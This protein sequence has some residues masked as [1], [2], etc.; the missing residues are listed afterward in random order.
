M[1]KK[2]IALLMTVV[3][4]PGLMGCTTTPQTTDALTSTETSVDEVQSAPL[5]EQLIPMGDIT[6]TKDGHRYQ[7][8]AYQDRQVKNVIYVSSNVMEA[9]FD[10]NARESVALDGKTFESL[11]AMCEEKQVAS[12]TYDDVLNAVYI[13]SYL[14]DSTKATAALLS[15]DERIA[16]YGLGE[17]SEEAITYQEFF[18]LVDKA[19][20]IANAQQLSTWKESFT[21]MRNSQA[22]LTRFEGMVAILRMVLVLGDEYAE[23]NDVDYTILETIGESGWQELDQITQG[24]QNLGNSL[25]EPNYPYTLGGFLN[26]PEAYDW[27]MTGI[28]YSY[29]VMRKSNVSGNT[30]FDYDKKENTMHLDTP[31]TKNVAMT[32][33]AR[34][35]DSTE[36]TKAESEDYLPVTDERILNPNAAFLPESLI[37]RSHDIVNPFD[38]GE[39]KPF[40][41]VL[42]E[43]S[44]ISPDPLN[45]TYVENNIRRYAN[46]GFNNFRYMVPYFKLFTKDGSMA[47]T[48]VFEQLDQVVAT[49]LQYKIH[50]NFTLT[51]LPGRWYQEGEDYAYYG[52]F[53]LFLNPDR[54]EE[55]KT[56]WRTIAERYKDVPECALSFCSNWETMNLS[57]ST[58]LPSEQYTMQD[59]ASVCADLIN[60]IASVSPQRLVIY[61]IQAVEGLSL[62]EEAKALIESRCD[63]SVFMLNYSDMP[64]VYANMTITEGEHIDNCNR[65]MFQSLY[66]VTYYDAQSDVS[67]EKPLILTGD[68][69]AG[70]EVKLYLE[71]TYDVGKLTVYADGEVVYEEALP[72]HKEYAV[73]NR[74]SGYVYYAE[75]N[76]CISLTLASDVSE[77]RFEN[78]SCCNWSGMAVTLPEQ[79]AVKRWFAPSAYESFLEEG[80]KNYDLFPYEKG[81]STILICPTIL[82]ATAITIHSDISYSTERIAAQSNSQTVDAWFKEAAELY[83]G[84]V[85]RCESADFSGEYYSQVHYFEDVLASLQKYGLGFFS[86]DFSFNNN[87]FVDNES[88]LKR[89]M[90]SSQN[91]VPYE[92]GWLRMDMFEVYE[93]YLSKTILE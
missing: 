42:S 76:K 69:P 12:Y 88:A 9:L 55:A 6:I 93:K 5:A 68:L 17:P 27:A 63:N 89:F 44:D 22:T 64:F 41:T 8:A 82:D 86:N 48:E 72:S 29:A 65:S 46:W 24:Q 79:Y 71:R 21:D 36:A 38:G 15:E 14:Y 20:E 34:L 35:L 57:L 74:L 54:Q 47:S 18:T 75:S 43:H 60:E 58:G 23:F 87:V 50:L 25:F 83:P 73:T 85:V 13:W 30:L 78:T 62:S 7:T 80:E 1:R 33:L 51:M 11:T 91:N 16:Y 3:M 81:N 28:A 70:T 84:A 92:N 90:A 10:E 56:V 32:V 59:A 52:E 26:T 77:I 61:E 49:A 4:L 67:S 39:T 53:D 45:L 19:A 37:E 66:P 40:G 31:L 2:A